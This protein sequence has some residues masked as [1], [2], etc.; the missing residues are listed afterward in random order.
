M[1]VGGKAEESLT[2]HPHLAQ[3]LKKTYRYTFTLLWAFM[4]C[5]RVKLPLRYLRPTQTKKDKKN[6]F[7]IELVIKILTGLK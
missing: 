5:S 7:L 3:K 1:D 4:T 6:K 2:I